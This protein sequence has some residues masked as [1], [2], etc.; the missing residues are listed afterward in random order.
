MMPKPT[1]LPDPEK[2][3]SWVL[4]LHGERTLHIAA[5]IFFLWAI[6][7]VLVKVL[8]GWNDFF[9]KRQEHVLE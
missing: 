7:Q 6:S 2:P 9:I 5:G 1:T 4:D 3:G 8:V